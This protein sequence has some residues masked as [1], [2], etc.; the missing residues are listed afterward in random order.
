MW[1]SVGFWGVF[2]SLI[3]RIPR[4]GSSTTYF[5]EDS[6]KDTISFPHLTIHHGISAV[7]SPLPQNKFPPTRI[8]SM[9]EKKTILSDSG[10]PKG[11]PAGVESH[12]LPAQPMRSSE[13]PFTL[14]LEGPPP[15]R[16]QGYVRGTNETQMMG[17][18]RWFH[19][20][21][22]FSLEEIHPSIHSS[23]NQ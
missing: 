8:R 17:R 5:I 20:G 18:H 4:R 19:F 11:R 2:G 14:L 1:P 12:L 22:Y 10:S 13:A 3:T 7:F 21:R 9:N 15:H 6:P 16:R 23:S